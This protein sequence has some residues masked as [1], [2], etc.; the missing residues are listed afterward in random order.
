MEL[1]LNKFVVIV[2]SSGSGKSSIVRALKNLFTASSGTGSVR[3]GEA[4][5]KIGLQFDGGKAVAW[6][7]GKKTNVYVTGPLSEDRFEKV[8]LEVPEKARQTLILITEKSIPVYIMKP[9]NL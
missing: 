1:S 2:G 9:D 7:K 5:Y 6:A 8:G 3:W 4:N